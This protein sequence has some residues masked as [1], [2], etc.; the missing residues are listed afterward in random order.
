[1]LEIPETATIAGQLNEMVRGK[2]IGRVIAN[3]SPHKL[4]FYYGD[5]AAYSELL[6]GQTV[7]DSAGIGA[8][9]EITAGSRRIVCGDGTNLRYYEDADQAPARHQLL[10]RFEDG[11]A[12]A[13]AVQ[14]YGTL[15]AFPEG[16]PQSNYYRAAK[17]KPLPLSSAFD[18]AYFDALYSED[19]GKLSAKAFLA[20]EQRIPGLGNGVLQDILFQAGVH[21]RRRMGTLSEREYGKL[22]RFLK[23]T[24][25]EMT[26]L[27]GRD[28]E[29][30]LLGN[31]GGYRTLLSRHTVGRPCPV[32]GAEIMKAAYLG[33][34]VYWCP[35]CQPLDRAHDPAAERGPQP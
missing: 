16:A 32:C 24:L 21:P 4:A 10:I 11:S 30:D 35:A 26:R 29:K 5:P 15:L 20:T 27:G 25:A 28:T 6:G 22:F 17:E 34:A 3:A 8:L 19:C 31:A 23:E 14:M 13:A 9:V 1:M 18:R 12:L 33:G 2:T 7:G